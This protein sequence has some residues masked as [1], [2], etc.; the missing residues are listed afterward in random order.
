MSSTSQSLEP[1]P[2]FAA[3]LDMHNIT[4]SIDWYNPPITLSTIPALALPMLE[5]STGLKEEQLVKHI[6]LC[7]SNTPSP[8]NSIT[9]YNNIH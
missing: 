4:S 2:G 7:V 6:N 8:P 3:N 1:H 5:D 9:A